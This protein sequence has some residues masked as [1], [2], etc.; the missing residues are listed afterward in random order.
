MEQQVLPELR[1]QDLLEQPLLRPVPQVL[2][3]V[4][5]QDQQDP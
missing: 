4:A 2:Q 3:E 5:Q 1:L